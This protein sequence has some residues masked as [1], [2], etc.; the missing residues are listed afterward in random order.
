LLLYADP[1]DDIMALVKKKM[2]SMPLAIL[3]GGGTTPNNNKPNNGGGGTVKPK[4][5][6]GK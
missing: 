1:A 3:P 4:P 6:G 5:A 2:D